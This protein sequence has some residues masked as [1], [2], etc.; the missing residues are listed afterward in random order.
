MIAKNKKGKSFGGCV[1]YVLNEGCEILVAEGVMSEDAATIIRDF[2]IQRSGRPEIKQPVGHIAVS[3]SPEDS[4]RMTNDFMLQLA[5]EYMDEIKIGRNTQYIIVRHHNT[6]HEHFHIVY[7]RIDNDLKLI[8]VNNDYKRNVKVCK[9]LKDKY[10]LTYGIGKD[11]VNR[12]KLKGA[13]KV[14]YEIHDQITAVLPKCP[15]YDEL[16][17]RLKQGGITIQ[18]KYRSGSK[19][20]DKNIQGISFKKGDYTFKGSEIDRKFSY[21][22]I[23]K[24]LSSNLNEAWEKIK[25]ILIPDTIKP[26]SEVGKHAEPT[27]E[28]GIGRISKQ[29]KPTTK[30]TVDD[31]RIWKI[32]MGLA[33]DQVQKR[34]VL[35]DQLP[36]PASQ[37]PVEQPAEPPQPE[38]KPEPPLKRNPKIG[39]IRLTDEQVETLK[40]GDYIFLENMEK[41]DGSGKFSSYVFTDLDMKY[42]FFSQTKPDKFVKYGKYEMRL[43]DKRRIEKGYITRAKVKWYGMGN[44]AYPYLWKAKDDKEESY[45]ESWDDPRIPEHVRQQ[46]REQEEKQNR[47]HVVTPPKNNGPKHRR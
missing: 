3:F 19:K 46:K 40:N 45:K 44:Y 14:K 42:A 29:S 25:D 37:K 5:R 36:E 1:R 6:D 9:K 4:G 32:A 27:P 16:E 24:T 11:K 47:K 18:Y 2:A 34:A 26:E 30:P 20:T 31:D 17:K 41:K 7:N 21:G 15:S 43:M 28:Q 38:R 22:N 39:G 23:T 10:G 12:P 33:E 8:S 35:T 13:D